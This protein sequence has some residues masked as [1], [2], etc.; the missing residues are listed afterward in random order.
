MP[1]M[2]GMTRER[3]DAIA[4]PVNTRGTVLS[5]RLMSGLAISA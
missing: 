5:D 4:D 3:F 2:P 1:G